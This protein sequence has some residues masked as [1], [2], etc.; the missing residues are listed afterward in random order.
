M[1]GVS[2]VSSLPRVM[3]GN[4]SVSGGRSIEDEIHETGDEV[5]RTGRRGDMFLVNRTCL[6]TVPPFRGV[7]RW[8]VAV[9]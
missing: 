5:G 9:Q 6:G 7:P 2:G 3:L 1:R 4:S 8:T